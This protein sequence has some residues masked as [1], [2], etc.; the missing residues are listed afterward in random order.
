MKL[1]WEHKPATTPGDVETHN[2][3]VETLW[4]WRHAGLV[5][6]ASEHE[7]LPELIDT[8][9][10]LMVCECGNDDLNN[11]TLMSLADCGIYSMNRYTPSGKIY[12]E[13]QETD[14][15]DGAVAE[16]FGLAR[17]GKPGVRIDGTEYPRWDWKHLIVCDKC[18]KREFIWSDEMDK[19][20][21]F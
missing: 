21:E 14:Y 16:M 18:N 19:F 9:K 4:R 2:N 10:R 1:K 5:V 8:L 15:M 17:K 12:A 3:M 13:H 11:F 7:R 20:I 6:E